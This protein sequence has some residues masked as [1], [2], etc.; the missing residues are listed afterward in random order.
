MGWSLCSKLFLSRERFL[1]FFLKLSVLCY[2]SGILQ[3]GLKEVLVWS[4]K[5]YN[6]NRDC[7]TTP[8]APPAPLGCLDYPESTF[9]F[10][11][12]LSARQC[13]ER[14]AQQGISVSIACLPLVSH[15]LYTIGSHTPRSCS[16]VLLFS[17]TLLFWAVLVG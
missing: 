4:S 15:S 12:V 14:N 9:W 8:S 6:V 17:I 1:I 5:Q 3:R 2:N 16:N 13:F 10:S 11:T 7:R